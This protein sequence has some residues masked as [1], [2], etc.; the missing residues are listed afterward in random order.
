MSSLLSPLK[1]KYNKQM[2]AEMGEVPVFGTDGVIYLHRL[3]SGSDE[4]PLSEKCLFDMHSCFNYSRYYIKYYILLGD[5]PVRRIENIMGYL[6]C[7]NGKKKHGNDAKVYLGILLGF[8]EAVAI[9]DRDCLE[10]FIAEGQVEGYENNV[11]MVLQAIVHT[12]HPDWFSRID[13]LYYE[14]NDGDTVMSVD[15]DTVTFQDRPSFSSH[16]KSSEYL[17]HFKKFF[18]AVNSYVSGSNVRVS[19]DS[20]KKWLRSVIKS[21]D[22]KTIVANTMVNEIVR[23]IVFMLMRDMKTEDLAE[24]VS[25]KK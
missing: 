2:I 14:V 24:V 7:C 13:I 18:S 21:D 23:S 17:G 12:H 16:A 22:L 25:E 15:R 4:Q 3:S 1:E 10:K 9:L 6:D 20:R 19:N 8:F 5:D 11:T